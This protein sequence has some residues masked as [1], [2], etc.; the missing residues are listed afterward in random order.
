MSGDYDEHGVKKLSTGES[1]E[2]IFLKEMKE[3]IYNHE[4]AAFI[5]FLNIAV[6]IEY[7]G[8]CLDQHDFTEE[9]HS[10]DRFNN[11]LKELFPKKYHKHAKKDAKIYLYECFRCPYVH[12][13]RPGKGV[14]VTH[15]NESKREGTIHLEF[16]ESDYFVLVLE[17][18]FDDFE[19]ACLKLFQKDENKKLPTK[20]MS[21][22]YIKYIN[23]SENK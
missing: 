14:V 16:T 20:K 19:S 6:G 15:R 22:D 23:I 2:A 9:G 11:A 12:Q 18:F 5:K 13:L 1:V 21:Q 10:E 7:L 17:D 3:I 4:G 8:A